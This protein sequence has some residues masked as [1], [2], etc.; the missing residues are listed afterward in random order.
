MNEWEL[1]TS[2]QINGPIALGQSAD[3]IER[4]L[5]TEYESY[6]RTSESNNEILAFD[7]RGIHVVI[8]AISRNVV[9]IM[10]FPPNR[11]W[12][13][14]IQLLQQDVSKLQLELLEKNVRF[15]P[16]DVGLWNAEMSVCLIS[17]DESTDC[18]Q[19]GVSD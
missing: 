6:R 11:V 19:I 5:G 4:V 2:G 1:S 8:D 10:L 12:L 15:E 3:N 16:D 18:V 7:A 9:G 17:V 14:G 13:A